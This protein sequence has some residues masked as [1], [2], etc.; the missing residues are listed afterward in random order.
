MVP[1]DEVT[2]PVN[3]GT[4]V[5]RFVGG[6]IR[7]RRV[8]LGLSQQQMANLIGVTYQQAHKYER[9]INRISAGR[10]YE[11]AR[12]LSVPVS[13]F[14]EGLDDVQGGDDLSLRQ[15]MC[16]ELARNFTQIPNERHREALSQLA[17]VLAIK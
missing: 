13:F 1:F 4:D 8:M 7:E 10:L 6:R 3:R 11:I 14:Y 16:L 5:D 17:R 12:V 9:G 2:K 15:R